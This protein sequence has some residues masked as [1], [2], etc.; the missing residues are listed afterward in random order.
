MDTLEIFVLTALALLATAAVVTFAAKL[1][2][3]KNPPIGRFLHVDGVDLHYVESGAGEPVVWFHGNVSMVQDF[4]T[5]G[6]TE[7][8]ARRGR[9][10]VIA[11]DRPG[12]GYTTRPRN[13]SWTAAEQADLIAGALRQL[14]VSSATVVGHSWGTLVATAL[15][16]KHPTLVRS[17]VL[18]GGYY[19]PQFRLDVLMVKP[20]AWPVIGD[21]FRY[22][23]SPIFGVLT[24][25][26]LMRAMFG[27]PRVPERFKQGFPTSLTLRPWQLRASAE[28]GA[29][30]NEQ[31]ATLRGGYDKL[32][33]STAI[34]AGGADRIVFPTKQSGELAKVTP[35]CTLQIVPGVGHMIHHEAGDDVIE[36]I[37]ASFR[38]RTSEMACS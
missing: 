37:E 25:P 16:Q 26:L 17:L 22:T 36:A 27:P 33:M 21:I 5:S 35:N 32:I 8:L 7:G 2:E 9:Y 19:F 11:F 29:T 31:V 24:M 3:R 10:R 18:L 23:I 38:S 28:E 13:K 20:L 1:A 6:I 30:M 4:L 15:A 34:L 14:D 12:Y